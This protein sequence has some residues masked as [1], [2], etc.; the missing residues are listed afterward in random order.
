MAE[1]QIEIGIA[2]PAGGSEGSEDEES[3]LAVD[4]R[5]WR[6]DHPERE[7]WCVVRAYEDNT[8]D[9][10]RPEGWAM[11]RVPGIRPRL[12]KVIRAGHSVTVAWVRAGEPGRQ[13]P[14]VRG[15]APGRIGQACDIVALHAT[16]AANYQRTGEDLEAGGPPAGVT[17]DLNWQTDLLGNAWLEPPRSV[18]TGKIAGRA[19]G[20]TAAAQGNSTA[21]TSGFN[22]GK[23][24]TC[25]DL[26][27]AETLWQQDFFV[28][29]QPGLNFCELHLDA[30]HG[31]LILTA[32]NGAGFGSITLVRI[33]ACTGETIGITTGIQDEM[34]TDPV[35][36]VDGD[37]LVG[38][39]ATRTASLTKSRRL[40]VWKRVPP[41]KDQVVEA[42]APAYQIPVPFGGPLVGLGASGGG[43]A[44]Y[45]WP[46]RDQA[47]LLVNERQD[48]DNTIVRARLIAWEVRSGRLLWTWL[49]HRELGLEPEENYLFEQF[50][51]RDPADGALFYSCSVETGSADKSFCVR[52]NAN[53][54][55][56]W[57]R[58]I[59]AQGAGGKKFNPFRGALLLPRFYLTHYDHN[60]GSQFRPVLVHKASGI[61]IEGER[62]GGTFGLALDAKAWGDN[63]IASFVTNNGSALIY[64]LTD[65]SLCT[66]RS[67]SH[68]IALAAYQ[69][70]TPD[71]GPLCLWR[72]QIYGINWDNTAGGWRV[73]RWS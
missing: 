18:L 56:E 47:V 45:Y 46:E 57:I 16:G 38:H 25:F 4:L 63:W 55:T 20:W 41:Q 17:L 27:T 43:E 19:V 9:L 44:G 37:F 40:Q 71:A 1:T 7:V 58:E 73:R 62:P 28:E 2:L 31:E 61:T 42:Y 33:S 21:S 51:I 72:S 39:V 53:G 5:R 32:Q 69:K 68:A 3:Y 26:E 11:F 60:S 22:I 23:R 49:P 13:R 66:L 24:V 48:G 10:D 65:H 64:R 12:F 15:R 59:S 8:F 35:L 67:W 36:M 54:G 70:S 30:N 34:R 14:Y 6:H 50:L 29:T 52:I